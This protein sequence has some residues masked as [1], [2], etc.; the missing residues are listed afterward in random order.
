MKVSVSFIVSAIMMVSTKGQDPIP[1][2]VYDCIKKKCSE[3]NQTTRCVMECT[4]G[5]DT[6]NNR[7]L[8]VNCA[9]VCRPLIGK[10]DDG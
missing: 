7:K 2:G 8:L 6:E 9:E 4:G 5:V 10:V 1:D 3:E